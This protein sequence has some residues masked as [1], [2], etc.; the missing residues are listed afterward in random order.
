MH[1]QEG[2]FSILIDPVIKK[3]KIIQMIMIMCC[4][5]LND[6]PLLVKGVF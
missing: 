6:M 2:Y 1:K 3:K 5:V 4:F